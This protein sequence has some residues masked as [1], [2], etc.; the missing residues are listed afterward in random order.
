M[1]DLD[2]NNIGQ[3]SD[4]V[5]VMPKKDTL[6]R[7][8]DGFLVFLFSMIIITVTIQVVSR[9]VF[10]NPIL[11]TEELARYQLIIL[12]FTGS[13]IAVRNR[14][15]VSFDFIVNKYPKKIQVILSILNGIIEMGFY[16]VSIVLSWQMMVF[17]RNRYFVTVHI[18]RSVIYGFVLLG[19]IFMAFHKLK[20]I[21]EIFGKTNNG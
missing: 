3:T 20:Q 6:E 18:S 14:S 13:A 21:T 5:I 15:H 17:S 9:Y 10:N 19:F 7:I 12:T 11:W 2:V 4:P 8:E 16:L 1:A